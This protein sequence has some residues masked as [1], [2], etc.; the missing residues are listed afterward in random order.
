MVE[1]GGDGSSSSSSSG[2]PKLF[3]LMPWCFFHGMWSV[4][5]VHS[6]ER[7]IGDEHVMGSAPWGESA[8]MRT[9]WGLHLHGLP[10]SREAAPGSIYD[11]KGRE[12]NEGA[13]SVGKH[14]NAVRARFSLH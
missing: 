10:R 2:R 8:I 3:H 7:E 14:A 6:P 11:V 5:D 12:I 13:A 9:A 1:E 4:G